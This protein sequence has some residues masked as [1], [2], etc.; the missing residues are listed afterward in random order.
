MTLAGK[1]AAITGAGNGI[2]RATAIEF[3]RRGARI[4]VCDIDVA[5]SEETVNLIRDTGGDA[6]VFNM[7][8]GDASS[9]SRE[10]TN[11]VARFGGLHILHANAAIELQ[12]FISDI[13][14][15]EWNRVINVNLT[16]VYRCAKAALDLFIP[17]QSGSILITASPHAFSTYEEIGAYAAS[18]GGVVAFMRALALESAKHGIRVNCLLPGTIDTPMVKR[19]IESSSDPEKLRQMLNVIHPLGRMGRPEEVAKCAAFLVSDD[20]SFV[21]GACLAVDGGV[22]AKLG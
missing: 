16:G 10:F 21:T 15:H 2:G 9:V 14:E 20:A 4:A 5:A 19:E 12:K 22:M 11:I 3:A 6:E 8:V 13:Q 17:Q 7:D 1:V 18:K